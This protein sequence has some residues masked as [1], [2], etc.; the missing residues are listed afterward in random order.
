MSVLRT[1]SMF[2]WIADLGIH[3]AKF[4]LLDFDSTPLIEYT[5]FIHLIFKKK[6]MKTDY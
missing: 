2:E 1:V 4:H 5:S 6:I 3:T